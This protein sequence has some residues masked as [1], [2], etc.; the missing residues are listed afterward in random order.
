M[1]WVLRICGTGYTRIVDSAW[2]ELCSNAPCTKDEKHLDM[3]YHNY[4][5]SICNIRS[6]LFWATDCYHAET[7]CLPVATLNLQN[8]FSHTSNTN[9]QYSMNYRL[10]IIVANKQ[11]VVHSTMVHH[12][13][14]PGLPE[15]NT[16][17]NAFVI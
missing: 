1:P 16:K 10:C 4:G 15:I 17:N 6:Q 3:S 14:K 2:S 9:A 7:F 11:F 13:Y 12:Q 5:I 8:V